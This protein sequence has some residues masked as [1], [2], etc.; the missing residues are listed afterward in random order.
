LD[1]STPP[2]DSQVP[3]STAPGR[4]TAVA[5]PGVPPE[6]GAILR[7]AWS[8]F[9]TAWPAC[10]VV[11]WGAAAAAWV[12][13][14]LLTA[15]LASF[16]VLIGEPEITPVLEFVQFLG[17]ILIPAWL[18]IGQTLAFLK[19]AR[20]EPVT[21]ED[22]FRGVPWLLTVLLATGI[23]LAI[24]AI[25]CLMIY[26]AAEAFVALHGG[27]ALA[28]MIRG[29]LP[30]GGPGIL[31][32]FLT[33]W[34][35]LLAIT[36][37]VVVLSYA[38]FL[39]VTVRLGQFPFL[40]IDRGAGVLESHRMSI[41]LTAGRASTVFLVYLA[42]LTINLAGLL[43][44]NVGLLLTLPMTSLLSAVTYHALCGPPDPADR[45]EADR[46]VENDET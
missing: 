40:I 23:L 10:L 19:I 13:L 33:E 2:V 14:V 9:A 12:I 43:A 35:A 28:A 37:V 6:V 22:L 26:G 29:L 21:L 20:R 7:E 25:P 46:S 17:K 5:S 3:D 4:T 36:I 8:T 42:Q 15:T 24:A 30:A 41:R 45:P 31:I 44:F 38:A 16:N 39:A 11:Y 27:D 32:S 18:W 1:T 34:L